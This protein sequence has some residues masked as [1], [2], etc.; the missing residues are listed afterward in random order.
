MKLCIDEEDGRPQCLTPNLF[1]TLMIAEAK[2]KGTFQLLSAKKKRDLVYSTKVSDGFF[3]AKVMMV[4]TAAKQI[5]QGEIRDFFVLEGAMRNHG[6]GVVVV[7][8]SL[9]FWN[10]SRPI[11]S[12]I[13]WKLK[14]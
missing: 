9:K 4:Q 5:E 1:P 13:T 3:E 14:R 12:P 2:K 6:D 11:G 7:K 8:E 10:Y